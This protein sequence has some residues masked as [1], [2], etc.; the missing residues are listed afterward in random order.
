MADHTTPR[1]R[2]AKG[3]AE[4]QPQP[5]VRDFTGGVATTAVEWDVRV[6]YDFLFSLW[7]EAGAT[8]DLP[9]EDRRWLKEARASLGPDEARKVD[10]LAKGEG[11]IH[12]A[13][14]L[15]ERRSVRTPA[16]VIAAFRETAPRELAR[17]IFCEIP[18]KDPAL[19]A[20]LDRA[21][22]GDAVA[23]REIRDR[24]LEGRRDPRL[25]LLEDPAGAVSAIVEALEV[26]ARPFG[27][28]QARVAAILE[29]DVALRDED[30]RTLAGLEIVERTT[31]G[32][33]MHPDPAVRRVI[34]APSYFSRPF[35]L[36]L[37]G[38]DWRFFAYPVADAALEQDPLAPPPGLLRYHRALGD[39]TRLRI[40]R[41]LSE[42]DLYPTEIAGLLELSK[43]TVSHHLAQLRAAGLVTV[44]E[45]GAY[46]SYSLRRDRL[47][48]AG[49]ELRR[50]L[51]S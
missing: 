36:L 10:R 49:D 4:V 40:L 30:R 12:V 38:P 7:E 11:L 28:V 34:L 14:A 20:T 18:A 21:I 8:D 42:K 23:V 32:V 5:P 13:A 3:S 2:T 48:A 33:R 27:A 37:A 24:V 39:G 26:W 22:D 45:T 1:A 44:V 43:P 17:S 41:L 46:L 6:A 31:G 50:F 16:E 35:N 51:R 9:A 47:D 15:V 19:A 29:R 25:A